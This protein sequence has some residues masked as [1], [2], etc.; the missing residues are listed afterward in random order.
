[1]FTR[2][3][4]RSARRLFFL[5]AVAAACSIPPSLFAQSPPTRHH[6]LTGALKT[7][8]HESWTNEDGL[9]Q[10]SIS[11]IAQTPDG[12][13][14]IGTQ[15]GLVR[16]DGVAFR[17]FDMF[18]TPGMIRNWVWSLAVGRDSSVWMGCDHGV[19]QSLKHGTVADRSPVGHMN[20]RD[21]RW[22]IAD[23]SG[24][25]WVSVTA[26][27]VWK[28]SGGHWASVTSDRLMTEV[29]TAYEDRDGS[30]WFG[31]KGAVAHLQNGVWEWYDQSRG[32]P[33]VR[34]LQMERDSRGRLLI[35]TDGRGLH[36][37][38]RG[39]V[40]P[41]P[42]AG[43]IA[44]TEVRAIR[45]DS[46]GRIWVGTFQRGLYF[47]S[48]G[49]MAPAIQSAG[50]APLHVVSIMIDHEANLWF[51]TD[52]DGLHLIRPGV[53][54]V[55]V[56]ADPGGSSQ[57]WS[58]LAD[59]EDLV[60]GTLGLGLR[61]MSH[62]A[63]VTPPMSPRLASAA[64]LALH[65]DADKSLWIGA[66]HGVFHEKNGQTEEIL[67]AGEK[68][69]FSVNAI[70][71]DREGVLWIGSMSGMFR[72]VGGCL[73]SVDST[74]GVLPGM[75][76]TCFLQDRNGEIWIGTDGAGLARWNGGHLKFLATAEDPAWNTV[77]SLLE[78]SRGGL[79]VGTDGAGMSRLHDGHWN[80]LTVRHGLPNNYINSII[81]D[82]QGRL[83]VSTNFGIFSAPEQEFITAAREDRPIA[84]GQTIQPRDGLPTA[85]LSGGL[86]SVSARTSDGTIWFASQKGAVGIDPRAGIRSGI[87]PPVRIE[88]LVADGR[89]I[90][91]KDGI[92][93][94]PG[95]RA[96]EFHF[97]GISYLMPAGTRYRYRLEGFDGD[98]VD[99]G[100][101]RQAT[102]TNLP[103]GTY[104]F[105]VIAANSS[106]TWNTTGDELRLLLLPTI[107]QTE[108]FILLC[109][110]VAV[111]AVIGV[112]RWRIWSLLRREK[113]L[114]LRVEEALAHAHVLSGLLPIC[115]SCK[116]IRDD[117]GYW[118]Q[119]ELYIR[120]HS[121][122]MFSH[123][124][125]PECSER[126]YGHVVHR[127]SPDGPEL[128]EPG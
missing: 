4:F 98:W 102:Y 110:I 55:V 42:G 52:G 9:Q 86:Q 54:R 126:L 113:E 87:P 24:A 117:K 65:Q 34:I 80:S 108:W 6:D 19:V 27:G 41:F 97:V 73:E 1:M 107:W 2:Y 116:K 29:W 89:E 118:N 60:F 69:L 13:L 35:G 101:M 104:T 61:R 128:P 57:V 120:D 25:L 88:R 21:A 3:R 37:L 51:G 8:I 99:G 109:G 17:G 46:S 14:W 66:M 36:L 123:S 58:V 5:L 26:R 114:Q 39:G 93:L 100:T 115:A 124:I 75:V 64:V 91:A 12:Y 16:F 43:A 121:D 22:L 56:P 67:M 59:S 112:Y 79:W 68:S 45:T 48:N 125:C 84:N 28:W 44:S 95:L 111:G 50:K 127:H 40:R 85:E 63:I 119:I 30:M 72:Y 18:N 71:R 78:D 10:N 76:V 92:E 23:R 20:E 77:L 32:V 83:W 70:F 94:G 90:E 106:G 38:A 33:N 47:I 103:P 11:S 49:V 96:L 122:A 15:D 74:N 53:A 81:A 82:A 105:R 7:F 62:G 31:L